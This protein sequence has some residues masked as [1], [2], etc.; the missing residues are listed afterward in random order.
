MNSSVYEIDEM[1]VHSGMR[2]Q[3]NYGRIL[4]D[5]SS[6]LISVMPATSVG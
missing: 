2:P 5:L 1:K 6:S 3:Y 4:F